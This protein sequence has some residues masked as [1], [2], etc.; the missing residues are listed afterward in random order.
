[1]S[2]EVNSARTIPRVGFV[3]LLN[4][5]KFR[6]ACSFASVDGKSVAVA[7]APM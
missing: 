4:P 7:F 6:V 1:V 5:T 3:P 2:D